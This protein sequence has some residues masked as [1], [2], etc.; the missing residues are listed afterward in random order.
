MRGPLKPAVSADRIRVALFEARPAGLTGR[1]LVA[2]TDLSVSQLRRGL[3]ELRDIAAAEGLPPLIWTHTDGY[4]FCGDPLEL[5]AYERAL[6]RRKLTEIGRL[7]TGTI[8]PHASLHPDDEWVRL[9]LAQ[10]NGVRAS[11]DMLVTARRS[12]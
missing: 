9:V 11:L 3:A 12:R 2:A 8:A 4:Q 10:L 1:Q 7:I 5:E 6:F